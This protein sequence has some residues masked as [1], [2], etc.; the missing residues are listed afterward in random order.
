MS[1]A[2]GRKTILEAL[3]F[4]N[5]NMSASAIAENKNRSIYDVFAL[6]CSPQSYIPNRR[7]QMLLQRYSALS[8]DADSLKCFEYALRTNLNV[9]NSWKYSAGGSESSVCDPN[10]NNYLSRIN[11]RIL[12]GQATTVTKGLLPFKLV[13]A[14]Q[15]SKTEH[16][17]QCQNFVLIG[18]EAKGVGSSHYEAMVQGFQISSDSAVHMWRCGLPTE[19][20]VVPLILSYSD[21]FCIYAVYLLPHCY[22]VL[23]QLSAPL[24]YLTFEGRCGLARWGIAL[25]RFAEETMECIRNREPERTE[26]V[27]GLH[28]A[29]SL[30]YK[31]LRNYHKSGAASAGALLDS[32]SS[33]RIYLE[34]LMMVYHHLSDVPCANDFF[35]FPLGV[36]SYPSLEAKAINSKICEIMRENIEKYFSNSN[37]LLRGGCPV[38]VYD[39]LSPDCW[40][41]E[42]PPSNAVE[43]YISCVKKAVEILNTAR[44]AHMDL[45]PANILW[46]VV[47]PRSG[48]G[49][50][51]S[52]AAV[53]CEDGGA[54]KRRRVDIAPQSGLCAPPAQS[55]TESVTDAVVEIRVIDL[56]DAVPFGFH[57]RHTD[58]LRSDSRYPVHPNDTRERIPADAFHND[59]FFEAVSS[60]ARQPNA[61][62]FSDYMFQNSDRIWAS[63]VA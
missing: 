5:P 25:A 47:T 19:N 6:P 8:D 28:I 15:A 56:E 13:L 54:A 35:L 18:S 23:V 46:R 40:Y 4:V 33:H 29:T 21:C 38:V 10:L 59:W 62:T 63:F 7:L 43:S 30:F 24:T 16:R 3:C 39:L 51:H 49:S 20:A 11:E 37:D 52:A 53:A 50:A 12:V 48:S 45:R 61:E 14:T 44:V 2:G 32:G 41:T 42:K 1:K 60:W 31:P 27:Y 58:V 55:V 36:I 9:L 22:P 17:I 57:F 34:S 26:M